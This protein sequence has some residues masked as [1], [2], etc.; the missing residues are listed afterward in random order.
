[1]SFERDHVRVAG[2]PKADLIAPR[3]PL[4]D[5]VVDLVVERYGTLLKHVADV[6]ARVWRAHRA[7]QTPVLNGSPRRSTT[8]DARHAE[9]L[10]QQATGRQLK[11]RPE[12]AYRRARDLG[13][14]RRT[15]RTPPRSTAVP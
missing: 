6:Q 7:H 5:A 2:R 15:R 8:G 12:T 11:V 3:H 13:R 1:V 10:D 9:V 4:L 14:S